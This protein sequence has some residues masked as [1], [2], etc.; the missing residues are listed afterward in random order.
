MAS[1]G[2]IGGLGGTLVSMC[3]AGGR[4][5][6]C[7]GGGG[8]TLLCVRVAGEHLRLCADGGGRA[9]S[10]VYEWRGNHPPPRVCIWGVTLFGPIDNN[11]SGI[12]K[13]FW[14]VVSNTRI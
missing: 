1:W 14:V 9:P 6:L 10:S 7:G 3:V 2:I 8:N 4:S 11:Y 13:N 5:R 12:I